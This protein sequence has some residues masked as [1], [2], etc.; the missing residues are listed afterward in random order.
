MRRTHRLRHKKAHAEE[1]GIESWLMSYADM[2]T[3]LLCFF[4]IF[5]STSEPKMDRL[6]AATKGMQA[7]FGS[8]ELMTPFNSIYRSLMGVADEHQAY[9]TMALEETANGLLIEL[10]SMAF[11]APNTAEVAVDQLKTLADVMM[12]LKDPTLENYHIT[13]EGHTDAEAGAKTGYPTQ[14][15]LSA[16]RAVKI[17]RI[18]IEQGFDPTRLSAV[19]LADTQPKLKSVDA[20]GKPIPENQE[21]N[22]RVVIRVERVEHH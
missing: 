11:F 19:G 16:A 1:G 21:R 15:E 17:V 18:F 22:R 8:V 10:S 12:T 7:R 4:I 3:L 20:K 6:A 13:V 5:I 9:Q 2:I 14:W